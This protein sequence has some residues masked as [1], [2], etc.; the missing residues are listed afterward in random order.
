MSWYVVY[1]KKD[2]NKTLR[3][4][5]NL[6]MLLW[7]G[8]RNLICYRCGSSEKLMRGQ[9]QRWYESRDGILC[10]KCYG[11]IY[12]LIHSEI[13][14]KWQV[15][16]EDY[17]HKSWRTRN[18]NYNKLWLKKT[19]MRCSVCSSK[20]LPHEVVACGKCKHKFDKWRVW[21]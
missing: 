3:T 5:K 1:F 6:S 20:L 4:T 12:R 17:V 7:V 9:I 13:D 2:D 18:A 8:F 14:R 19:Q 16:N 15:A 10:C 21:M 11:A